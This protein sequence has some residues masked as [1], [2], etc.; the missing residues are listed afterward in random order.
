MAQ[1][2]PIV[3]KV[4]TQGELDNAVNSFY[5]NSFR[6][7]PEGYLVNASS[8]LYYVDNANYPNGQ[9]SVAEILTRL[10]YPTSPGPD[11]NGATTGGELIPEPGTGIGTGINTGFVTGGSDPGSAGSGTVVTSSS[12]PTSAAGIL[13]KTE[14]TFAEAKQALADIAILI[15]TVADLKTSLTAATAA[16]ATSAAAIATLQNQVYVLRS[17]AGP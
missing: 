1:Y 3:L 2:T 16:A 14:V 10:G 17:T 11:P 4:W 6:V 7:T 8:P 5:Q 15:E 9:P 13:A 12:I